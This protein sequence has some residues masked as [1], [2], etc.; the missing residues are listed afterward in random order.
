MTSRAAIANTRD[1]VTVC[2]S[3]W[4]KDLRASA[5]CSELVR[6][7]SAAVPGVAGPRRTHRRAPRS[8]T[9]RHAIGL[10]RDTQSVG[11][12]VRRRRIAASSGDGPAILLAAIAAQGL[13]KD[14]MAL[15]F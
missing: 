1:T 4:M 11:R 7:G 15:P 13:F 9:S 2:M 3:A 12:R 10:Q 6:A 8:R 14:R 5:A